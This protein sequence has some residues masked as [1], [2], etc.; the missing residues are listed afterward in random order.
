[1]IFPPKLSVLNVYFTIRE[2]ASKHISNNN[3]PLGL[4]LGW[5]EQGF[6]QGERTKEAKAGIPA[7]CFH[8]VKACSQSAVKDARSGRGGRTGRCYIKIHKFVPGVQ[9]LLVPCK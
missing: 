5:V 8:K 9:R 6:P 4:E 2:N 3:N 1:M 7:D